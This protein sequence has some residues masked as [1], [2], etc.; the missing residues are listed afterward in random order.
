[1]SYLLLPHARRVASPS[2]VLDHRRLCRLHYCGVAA[3]RDACPGA[4]TAPACTALRRAAVGPTGRG[5]PS[6]RR[7]RAA[8]MGHAPRGRGP[9]TRCARGP[10]RRREREPSATVHLGRAWFRPS[11][12]E[13]DFSIL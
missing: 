2:W 9:R 1:V 3:G 5:W 11:D 12:T 4:V 7:L 6:K 13:I 10:S 8:H